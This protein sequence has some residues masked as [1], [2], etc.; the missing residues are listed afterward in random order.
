MT[1]ALR[2]TFA[3]HTVVKVKRATAG[4]SLSNFIAAV[5]LAAAALGIARFAWLGALLA[6]VFS[7]DG[8]TTIAL[9]A[10]GVGLAVLLRG[11]LDHS[12]TIIAYRT[13]S[14]VQQTA[15][16][17]P[18]LH[19]GQAERLCRPLPAREALSA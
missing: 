14:R 13:A 16:P 4:R 5:N 19:P 11:A 17:R 2:F 18:P 3:T 1:A 8:A 9:T 15:L 7:G 6:R 10:A 12:R